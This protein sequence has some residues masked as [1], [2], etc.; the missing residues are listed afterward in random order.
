[1]ELSN[2]LK[3]M[4]IETANSLRGSERRVF[5]AQVV[6]MMGKGGQRKAEL[7]L[8]WNRGTI[9]KGTKELETGIRIKDNFSARGR[10]RAEEHL[11]NL[12]PDIES[13]MIGGH[14]S[15]AK[16]RRQLIQTKGY[17]SELL[18]TEE[19]IRKKMKVVHSQIAN[20]PRH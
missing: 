10:K 16:M 8:G 15:A 18:P 5:M 17:N 20:A 9:R 7:E 3:R 4:Y 13:I 1:M 2:E 6:K 14:I 12:L 11:P 19:T